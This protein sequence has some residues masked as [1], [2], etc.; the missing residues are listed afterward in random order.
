MI[1]VTVVE[2][3]TVVEVET[4]TMTEKVAV[5]VATMAKIWPVS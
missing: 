4:V 2:D 5:V 1:M 3:S